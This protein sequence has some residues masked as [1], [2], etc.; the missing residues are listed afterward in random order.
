MKL[1]GRSFIIIAILLFIIIG[2]VYKESIEQ[3]IAS[4]NRIEQY[5]DI[6]N[7]EINADQQYEI[8]SIKE[9]Y[10]WNEEAEL[11]NENR[12]IRQQLAKNIA[13][14]ISVAGDVTIGTDIAYG[15]ENSFIHEVAR[16]NNDFN[17]FVENIRLI[18]EQDDLTIVNLETTLTNSTNKANKKFTFK[19]EPEY[20][21]ILEL[22]SVEAVNIANNHTYDYLETGFKDT[23]QALNDSGIAFF[24]YEYIYITQIKGIKIGLLGYEGWEFTEK[25]QKQIKNDLSELQKSTDL[26]IV[27]FHWGNENHL[28][29][30]AD[31]IDL[32]HFTIDNGADLVFGHHPHVIQGIEVYKD[33]YIVYSLGN[34]L[35]GGHRNP[36]DKDTFIF[37]QTF[38]FNSRENQLAYSEVEIIPFSI[39]SVSYRNNYQP[40]PL[41][42]EDKEAFEQRI[43]KLSENIDKK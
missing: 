7:D 10:I 17:Y 29:P 26:I 23:I 24:G 21:E 4:E 11:V 37:Q 3:V 43:L 39:S 41:T 42:G 18:F 20:A 33:K 31:Q 14:T 9:E 30:E 16:Q 40:T 5:D 36:A 13:I 34:F 12:Y 25:L 28:Y 22:A 32:A 2:F 27:S 38:Y 19:G 35:Y 1:I 8:S 15:Y 6:E